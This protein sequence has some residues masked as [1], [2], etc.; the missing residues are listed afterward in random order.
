MYE[1]RTYIRSFDRKVK[2]AKFDTIVTLKK[3]EVQKEQAR[4][5]L[6]FI[7]LYIIYL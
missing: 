7:A 3:K 1:I 4:R 5:L 6:F 2:I